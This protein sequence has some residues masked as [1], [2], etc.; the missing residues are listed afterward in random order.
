MCDINEDHPKQLI[1]TIKRQISILPGIWTV[2]NADYMQVDNEYILVI[3]D[4]FWKFVYAVVTKNQNGYTTRIHLSKCFT[5]IGFPKILQIDNGSAF[6]SKTVK[7]Y[8]ESI[9]VAQRF[10]SPYHHR[11]NAIV[12]RKNKDGYKYP[13]KVMTCQ[14]TLLTWRNNPITDWGKRKYQQY[15]CLR[16]RRQIKKLSPG[17]TLSE[18]AYHFVYTYNRSKHFKTGI[19]PAKL[20]L[21]TRD[22]FIDT[23]TPFHNEY[24]S[25]ILLNQSAQ[26]RVVKTKHMRRH[27]ETVKQEDRVLKKIMFR[28][29]AKTSHK[30][31]PTWEIPIE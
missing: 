5:T 12:E 2:L 7:E 29:D 31:Q 30:N 26:D 13:Q 6:I 1:Q 24:T 15:F 21:N 17:T 11:G 25:I 18:I 22:S 10:S 16:I 14:L 9:G 28:K 19:E 20:V 3:I 8:T 23:N 27:D 4:E